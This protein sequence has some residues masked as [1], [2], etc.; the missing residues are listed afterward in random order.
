MVYRGARN[1]GGSRPEIRPELGPDT[2]A[3][4]PPTRAGQPQEQ[5]LQLDLQQASGEGDEVPAEE[6]NR[7]EV[8]GGP[9]G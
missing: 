2:R 8:A 1:P 4:L 3:C 6:L 9:A 7:E 5:I